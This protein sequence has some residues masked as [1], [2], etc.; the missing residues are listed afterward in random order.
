MG[1][2]LKPVQFGSP[3][4]CDYEMLAL[5]L[6]LS[7]RLH[8]LQ[9]VGQQEKRFSPKRFGPLNG[10]VEVRGHYKALKKRLIVG[11]LGSY[12]GPIAGKNY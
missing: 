8:Q 5:E 3:S 10:P 7:R 2:H 4:I 9:S 11:L 12:I 1:L 6:C